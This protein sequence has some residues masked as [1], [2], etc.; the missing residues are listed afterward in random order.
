MLIDWEKQRKTHTQAHQRT[1]TH[2]LNV[3]WTTSENGM[4]TIA[5][6]V[7]MEHTQTQAYH[8]YGHTRYIN[9]ICARRTGVFSP[10]CATSKNV[11]FSQFQLHSKAQ[12]K[13][14]SFYGFSL[15][16]HIFSCDNIQMSAATLPCSKMLKIKYKID[17]TIWRRFGQFVY[18][19]CMRM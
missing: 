15:I 7:R 17:S 19:H 9:Q 10:G 13:V 8:N 1:Q 2:I 4:E 6:N 11:P 12:Y 16:F 3:I 18:M 14:I 5:R